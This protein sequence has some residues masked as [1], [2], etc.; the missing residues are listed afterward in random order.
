M[1][2]A[3]C[4]RPW[5]EVMGD[6]AELRRAIDLDQYVERWIVAGSM[7]RREE[8][9]AD[10]DLLAIPR[11]E[12]GHLFEARDN[13]L[14]RRLDRG[15]ATGELRRARDRRDRFC[16]GDR[17]RRI[18]YRGMAF[19]LQCVSA[20]QW[21][22]RLAIATGPHEFS[23][24][25]VTTRQRGGRLDD[26]LLIDE[27]R[28]WTGRRHSHDGQVIDPGTAL[29]TPEETDFLVLA[30]GWVE[31]WERAGAAE[32]HAAARRSMIGGAA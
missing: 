1:A 12:G 26:G 13:L 7:R 31:P 25:L 8:Q 32:R 28:V 20:D 3:T 17:K 10:V 9:V 21:G 15:V 14:W 23:R 4:R 5:H 29:E 2:I 6:I 16:W 11:R 24:Q 30:G 27:G 18:E 19:E 22:V